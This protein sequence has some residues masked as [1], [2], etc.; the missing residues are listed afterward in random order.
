MLF[1]QEPLLQTRTGETLLTLVLV[2][3][4]VMVIVY[5]SADNVSD[6]LSIE[7][8]VLEGGRR[9]LGIRILTAAQAVITVIIIISL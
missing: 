8:E 4:M 3:Q 5:W 2:F 1:I 9:A 7:K 6:P